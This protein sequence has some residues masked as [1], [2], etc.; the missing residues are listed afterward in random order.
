M[1]GG[2]IVISGSKILKIMYKIDTKTHRRPYIPKT[3]LRQYESKEQEAARTG[4]GGNVL[5]NSQ[6]TWG[7]VVDDIDKSRSWK[8]DAQG[9]VVDISLKA[10]SSA[11]R[12][13]LRTIGYF[14][15]GSLYVQEEFFKI[16]NLVLDFYPHN[17]EYFKNKWWNKFPDAWDDDLTENICIAASTFE[18]LLFGFVQK[19]RDYFYDSCTHKVKVHHAD[20]ASFAIV[21]GMPIY[22]DCVQSDLAIS[23]G[24]ANGQKYVYIYS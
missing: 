18:Q 17:K 21:D 5:L 12:V 3:Y 23:I 19:N 11:L 8:K 10:G 13:P 20:W 4:H 9:N 2:Q 24:Y 6:Q 22:D 16:K 15:I 1:H 7:L 14:T